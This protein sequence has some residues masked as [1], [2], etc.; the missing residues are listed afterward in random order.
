MK[1]LSVAILGFGTVGQ[2][3]RDVLCNHQDRLKEI[4]GIPV[5]ISTILIKHPEKH[6]TKAP[7]VRFTTDFQ[8]VLDDPAIDVV[9]EAIVGKEPA[10]SYLRQCIIAGKHVITAN[11]EMFQAHGQE[12]KQLAAEYD[13]G[14][15][16]DA[17]TAGGIPIIQT[18]QHLLQVNK[19]NRVQA[20][21]NGTSNYILT[22]MREN[23]STF[24]DA[25][26]KAQSLGYAE[27]DPTNDI[28]GYDALYKLKIL[29][30]LIFDEQPVWEHVKC[31][32]ISQIS[33]KAIKQE[34]ASGNRIKHIAEIALTEGA[35]TANIAPKSVS[36]EHPLY[37]IEGVNNAIHM[38]TDIIGDL[39]LSGP[40]A[41]AFPTASAMVED[42]CHIVNKHMKA[43]GK[44]TTIA[45]S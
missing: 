7:H 20:I 31:V 1:K 41:G 5:E 34:A 14:I 25:L 16:F 36:A 3:V 40:G 32:G 45:Y 6:H 26:L 38:K 33:A 9:F 2:G 30:E 10:Y 13:V 22:D 15:G 39:T 21:L 27:S 43:E 35:I 11:K 4:A 44:V 8:S 29:C 17:T 37:A 24:D 28:E 19:I 18:I 12:L 23:G 42:F